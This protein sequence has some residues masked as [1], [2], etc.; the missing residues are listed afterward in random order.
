MYSKWDI[1]HKQE[2]SFQH[3]LSTCLVF[4]NSKLHLIWQSKISKKYQD[5]LLSK[6]GRKHY[7]LWFWD[8]DYE[9]RSRKPLRFCLHAVANESLKPILER[10]SYFG[11]YIWRYY[12]PLKLA[13][14]RHWFAL[15]DCH[16]SCDKSQVIL[17][18]A[19]WE[20]LSN[21]RGITEITKINY[22]DA[23]SC[24]TALILI[25]ILWPCQVEPTGKMLST[26][27]SP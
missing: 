16:C 9:K 18:L 4:L 24:D 2:K 26:V 19:L 23:H 14:K 15:I 7:F 17:D 10:S 12:F 25:K 1:H 27:I 3:L 5:C 20:L 6:F 13:S 11:W 21:R 8:M 22:V